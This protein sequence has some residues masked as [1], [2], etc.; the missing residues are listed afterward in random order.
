L[1]VVP[2]CRVEALVALEPNQFTVIRIIIGLSW[3]A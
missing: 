2:L 1:A 3:T